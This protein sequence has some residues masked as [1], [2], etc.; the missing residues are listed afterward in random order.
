MIAATPVHAAA[1]AAI[2][3]AAFPA[4]SAW[5]EAAVTEVLAMPGSFGFL[6]PRGGMILARTV[7]GE[8]E[9]LTLAVAP[10]RQRHGHGRA[11]LLQA[12]AAVPPMPWYLEV[13]ADNGAALALYAAAGFI[14][15]GRRRCYYPEG[16]DALILQRAPRCD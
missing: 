9:I 3:A 4:E 16:T 2:H 7:A 14:P 10:E 13:A 11:L 15:C 8:A 6:E 12:F 1:L 5:S